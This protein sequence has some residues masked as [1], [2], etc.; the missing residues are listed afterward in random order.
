[1]LS[2]FILG[3]NRRPLES[4]SPSMS[5]PCALFL[6]SSQ[7]HIFVPRTIFRRAVWQRAALILVFL[8]GKAGGS[9]GLGDHNTEQSALPTPA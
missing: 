9:M 5:H 3:G 2:R 1:M 7:R 4:G 8:I 6:N